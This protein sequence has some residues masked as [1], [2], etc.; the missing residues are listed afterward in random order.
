MVSSL[1]V[2][3]TRGGEKMEIDDLRAEVAYLKEQ[4]QLL[5]EQVKYLS[6]KT[7]RQVK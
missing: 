4:N 3:L 1:R 5:Q 7:V 6:K 2:N